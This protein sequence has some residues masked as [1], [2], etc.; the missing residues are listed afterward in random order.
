M[1]GYTNRSELTFSFQK[2]EITLQIAKE[3]TVD[4]WEILPHH[5]PSEVNYNYLLYIYIYIY[6]FYYLCL[7]G[8]LQNLFSYL[9]FPQIVKEDVDLY[10]FYNAGLSQFSFDLLAIDGCTERLHHQINI[11]GATYSELSLFLNCYLDTMVK[12]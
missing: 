8:S 12:G 2:S 10:G 1:V 7:V 3:S 4:G 11:K 5:Y 9:F 6:N